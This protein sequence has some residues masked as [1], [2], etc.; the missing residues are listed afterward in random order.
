MPLSYHIY[1][2]I[3]PFLTSPTLV[4]PKL[5]KTDSVYRSSDNRSHIDVLLGP[6]PSLLVNVKRSPS[7]LSLPPEA[8]PPLSINRPRSALFEEMFSAPS[9]LVAPSTNVHV[10]PPPPLLQKGGNHFVPTRELEAPRGYSL[11]SSAELGSD[12]WSGAAVG[13]LQALL[14]AVLSSMSFRGSLGRPSLRED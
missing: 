3:A 4:T 13:N 7:A 8:S 1:L 5:A 11:R 10:R 2:Q 6:K 9:A 14:P 12:A